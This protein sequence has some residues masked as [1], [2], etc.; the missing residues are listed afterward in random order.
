M[1]C[2]YCKGEIPDDAKKCM[3]CGEWVDPAYRKPPKEEQSFFSAVAETAVSLLFWIF[4]L[5]IAV[6]AAYAFL[7]YNGMIN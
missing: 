3:N 1:L 4:I 5:I 6:I 2:P 7:D